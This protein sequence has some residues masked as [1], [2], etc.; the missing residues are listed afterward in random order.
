[1]TIDTNTLKEHFSNKAIPTDTD[2]SA[3]IDLAAT[4]QNAT[5]QNAV[6]DNKNGTI[7][8]NGNSITPA[9]DSKVVHDNHDGTININGASFTPAVLDSAAGKNAQPIDTDVDTLV[10]PGLYYVSA[11]APNNPFK[12]LMMMETKIQYDSNH[13]EEIQI[14]YELDNKSGIAVRAVNPSGSDLTGFNL[15]SPWVFLSDDSKVVHST[16]MRKPASDVV[17][18]EEVP[19]AIVQ[20]ALVNEADLDTVKAPGIYPFEGVSLINYMDTSSHWG[21]LKVDVQGNIVVQTIYDDHA[22]DTCAQRKFTGAPGSWSAWIEFAD[23][24]KVAHLSG[25]NNFDTVPTYGTNNKPFAINDTGATTSRPTSGIYA[26][27]QYYD[28]DLKKPIWYN[29]SAWTDSTGATV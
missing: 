22:S 5:G 19:Q 28:T 7:E 1:M 21:Y 16:D 2:F 14:S 10:K 25:T 27:Y 4:G 18:I 17:G 20:T 26:G 13:Y 11:S 12:A 29:G 8:V 3:L 6:V 24:S 9:E 15:S 23:D